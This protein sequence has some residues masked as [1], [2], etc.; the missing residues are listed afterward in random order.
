MT[1]LFR[2]LLTRSATIV[3]LRDPRTVGVPRILLEPGQ[4][5]CVAQGLC[6]VTAIGSI[7]GP[8]RGLPGD[9]GPA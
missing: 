4:V 6:A 3:P 7:F 2:V 9:H 1:I 8:S 5:R